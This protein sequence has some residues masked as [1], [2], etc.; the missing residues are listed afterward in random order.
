MIFLLNT[1]LY[2]IKILKNILEGKI[3]YYNIK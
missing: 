2:Y 1:Y 3:F